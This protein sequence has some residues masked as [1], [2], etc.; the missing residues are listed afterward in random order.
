MMN[1][2][3][4]SLRLA[5]RLC[6][7]KPVDELFLPHQSPGLARLRLSLTDQYVDLAL[8]A[9]GLIGSYNATFQNHLFGDFQS[10]ES[11]AIVVWLRGHILCLESGLATHLEMCIAVPTHSP[12]PREHCDLNAI[13]QE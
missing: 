7:V 6:L 9:S 5:N 2:S 4:V 3:L 8:V 11:T 13:Q 10:L 1:L 12:W